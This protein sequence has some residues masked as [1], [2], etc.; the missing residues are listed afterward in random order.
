MGKIDHLSKPD[1][2]SRRGEY[3]YTTTFNIP[4]WLGD[5]LKEEAEER[6]LRGANIVLVALCT[7]YFLNEKERKRHN[8]KVQE[9]FDRKVITEQEKQELWSWE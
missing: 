8:D 2:V 4:T 7:S 9:L 3:W 6:G 5:K 1:S